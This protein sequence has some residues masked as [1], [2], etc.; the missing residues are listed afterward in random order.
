[1]SIVF[2]VARSMHQQ[3]TKCLQIRKDNYYCLENTYIVTNT[4]LKEGYIMGHDILRHASLGL[5]NHFDTHEA[6]YHDT[7]FNH[8]SDMYITISICICMC[9]C[10][11]KYFS[12]QYPNNANPSIFSS[13]I[14][15][16]IC[17]APVCVF[18]RI[19]QNVLWVIHKALVKSLY[20]P[21]IWKGQL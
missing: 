3:V 20:P 21:Y 11:Y 18:V 5:Y 16:T 17:Y 14:S 4:V 9:V 15:C 8:C 7:I 12:C 1:M 13:V 19:V 2:I 10:L 6:E